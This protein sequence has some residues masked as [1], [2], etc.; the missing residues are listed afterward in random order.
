VKFQNLGKEV[1]E[2]FCF[3]ENERFLCALIASII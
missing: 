2:K 3:Q 1:L